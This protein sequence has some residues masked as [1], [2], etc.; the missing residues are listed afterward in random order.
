LIEC[1]RAGD[2]LGF[3]HASQLYRY[4]SVTEA[5]I[6]ILTNGI[7]YQFFTD[8]DAANRMNKNP[9]M[10]V[11]FTN[12]NWRLSD[13]IRKLSKNDFDLGDVITAAGEL[14]YTNRIKKLIA[15]EFSQPSEEFVVLYA[16]KVYVGRLTQK[17]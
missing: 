9:F 17:A 1:K 10:E 4:F 16:G 12:F 13:E 7:R 11:D 5:R 3:K 6:A 15:E 2:E 8:L 14:K